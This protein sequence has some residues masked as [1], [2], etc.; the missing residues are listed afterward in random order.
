MSRKTCVVP[1]SNGHNKTF[2]GSYKNVGD[3]LHFMLSVPI[4]ITKLYPTN[5][6]DSASSKYL[7][8]K[9]MLKVAHERPEHFSIMYAN[10]EMSDML[11]DSSG[12]VLGWKVKNYG[13]YKEISPIS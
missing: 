5:N 11:E 9:S 8:Q 1:L 10:I 12:T 2:R 6:I 4:P 13:E 7:L 3:E